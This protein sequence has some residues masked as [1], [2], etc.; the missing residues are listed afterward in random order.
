MDIISL[1]AKTLDPP[2]NYFLITIGLIVV[3]VPKFLDIRS[4]LINS[5]NERRAFIHKKENLELLKLQFEIEALRRQHDLPIDE[6]I[7]MLLKPEFAEAETPV[8]EPAPHLPPTVDETSAPEI[9]TEKNTY[10]Y[11]VEILDEDGVLWDM[12]FNASS[13][14]LLESSKEE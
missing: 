7:S 12:K 13:G 4:T 3:L 5:S 8:P 9:S 2:F 11:Q 14:E 6:S 1:L 10:V